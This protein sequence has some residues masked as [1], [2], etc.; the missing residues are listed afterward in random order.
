[1]DERAKKGC[2]EEE[3]EEV[4]NVLGWS[5]WEQRRKEMERR[6]WKEFWVGKRKGEEYFG[7]GGSGEGEYGGERWEGKILLWMRTNHRRMCE[8][9]YVGGEE[10]RSECEEREERDNLLLYCRRWVREREEVWRGW[11]GGWLWNEGWIDMKRML[12]EEEEVR[13][14]LIFTRLIGWNKRRWKSWREDGEESR[15]GGL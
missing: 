3:E 1:M 2:W 15:L 11:W 8:M 13:R 14:C 6:R 4:G 7:S 5:K 9:R 10:E 12:F